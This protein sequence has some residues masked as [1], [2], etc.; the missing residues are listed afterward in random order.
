MRICH[1][2]TRLI[3]GGAQENTLLTCEGL[4]QRG[5]DVLLLAGPQTGPEGSLHERAGRGGYAFEFVD[6][7]RREVRPLKDRASRKALTRRLRAWRPDVVHT[8]SSKAGVVGRLAARD[9]DVPFIV[10]TVHGMSFN[11][12]QSALKR[13]AFTMIERHCAT[14][15]NRIV[16]IADAMTE[17]S[18]A[19]RVGRA[20]QYCTIYSGVEVDL[21]DPGQYDRREVRRVWGLDDDAIVVGSIARMSAHKGYE[22]LMA[23][24]RLAVRQD[25]RLRFVWVGG[26]A[27]RER[28]EA[29]LGLAGLRERVI[30]T[31][32]VQP[33]E[34]PRLIAGMDMLVHASQWEGLPR[35]IVQALLMERPAI[36]F[37]IDGASEVVVPGQTGEL[38]RLND[39]RALADAMV[40]LAEAP[41]RR[42]QSGRAGRQRCMRRFDHRHMVEQIERLYA[43]MYSQDDEKRG[44]R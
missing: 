16:S 34:I 6:P 38:V 26:G 37:D 23:A 22:P 19:A 17:Q 28:F 27:W 40:R 11:R 15:T 3:V 31:G 9:A 43:A 1:I 36:S 29:Q 25:D 33:L 4:H 44:H 12:T 39:E 21:F 7:L 8:H 18:L 13:R 30:M 24:M 10:H 5:H 2:I 32:L 20:E 35:A 41:E 42:A 14:F